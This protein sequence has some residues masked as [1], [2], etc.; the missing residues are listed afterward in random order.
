MMRAGM[1]HPCARCGEC[2]HGCTCIIGQLFFEISGDDPCPALL[3]T[4]SGPGRFSCGM[5]DSGD[6]C[7]PG[8]ST[9]FRG[10]LGIGCG[11]ESGPAPDFKLPEQFSR[12]GFKEALCGNSD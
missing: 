2:C 11:C 12:T 7:R 9:F 10:L 5:V 8:A 3:P 4:T 6:K 1:N